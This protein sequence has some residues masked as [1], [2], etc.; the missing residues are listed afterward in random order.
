MIF[1]G[2]AVATMLTLFV[3]PVAY[4]LL[5]KK[6]CSENPNPIRDKDVWT[7][8]IVMRSAS[9]SSRSYSISFGLLLTCISKT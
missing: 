2:L 7:I 4:T 6:A 5:A 3:V 1:F 9:T 8:C